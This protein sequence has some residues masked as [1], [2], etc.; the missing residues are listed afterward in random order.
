MAVN[1]TVDREL[2]VIDVTDTGIGISETDSERIFEK[3]YR[4]QDDRVAGVTGS[5]MGLALARQVVR[6]HGGDIT[7]QS[8]LNKGSNFTLALPLSAEAA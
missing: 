6:L 2:V 5:G 3:F 4:A 8:E 7:V 1:I